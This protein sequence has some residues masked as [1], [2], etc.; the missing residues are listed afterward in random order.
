MKKLGTIGF[1]GNSGH[2]YEF[3]VYPYGVRFK[4]GT[5]GVYF[6]TS[7]QDTGNSGHRHRK[8]YVGQAP[9]LCEELG[10]HPKRGEFEERE[11]NCVCVHVTRDSRARQRIAEDILQHYQP[12]CN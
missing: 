12:P 11:A 8:I 2:K 9:D 4:P 3:T 1:V 10:S 5:G 6:V 7:R